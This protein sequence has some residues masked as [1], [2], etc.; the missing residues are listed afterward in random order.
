MPRQIQTEKSLSNIEASKAYHQTLRFLKYRVRTRAEIKR[1]LAG[2][3]FSIETITSTI[4]RL[5]DLGLIND[6][7][8]AKLWVENRR[9]FRPKGTY[10]LKAEL[11]KKGISDEII[12]VT[13]KDDDEKKNARAAISSRLSRWENCNT[14]EL[15]RKIFTFLRSRGFS[16]KTC[17]Q[18]CEQIIDEIP[19][20]SKFLR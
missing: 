19:E 4:H 8:F 5:E 13:L 1:Y 15:Q 17:T 18:L 9:R 10:A 6:H 11:K 2:K 20:D 12:D 14:D 16:Y 7:E 3:N